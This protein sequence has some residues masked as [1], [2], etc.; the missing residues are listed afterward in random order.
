VR[1]SSKADYAVRAALELAAAGEPLNAETITQ[2]QAIPPP[3]LKKILG[4]LQRGRVVVSQRGR[5]GGHRLARSPEEITIA[6]VLRA[7]EGPLATVRGRPPEETVYTGSAARLQEV[8][9][10]LRTNVREVLEQVT[11]ADPRR[12]PAAGGDR[13]AGEPPRLLGHALSATPG[14]RSRR[15][16][17]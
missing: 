15:S 7:V 16:R 8:W 6:D 14:P 11:L 12:G 9:I 5:D 2:R 1:V 4:E 10:A 3:F 13:R 17:R